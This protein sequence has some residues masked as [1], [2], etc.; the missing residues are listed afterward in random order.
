MIKLCIMISLR[1]NVYCSKLLLAIN[2]YYYYYR[3][4]KTISKLTKTPVA[5]FVSGQRR[6]YYYYINYYLS[7]SLN[8][9]NQYSN[10]H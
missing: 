4:K 5:G 1:I 8:I 7:V 10:L 2:Y 9:V 3:E 6:D